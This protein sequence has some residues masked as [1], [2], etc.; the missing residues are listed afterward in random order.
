MFHFI[1]HGSFYLFS[2][3]PS[4]GSARSSVGAGTILGDRIS[5]NLGEKGS[6][7]S[8]SAYW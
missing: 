2:P 5:A 6:M 8:A 1:F 4:P 3:T 7:A